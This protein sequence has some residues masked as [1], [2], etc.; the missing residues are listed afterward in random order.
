MSMS[1][2]DEIERADEAAKGQDPDNNSLQPKGDAVPQ[3]D[4][5]DR[6]VWG[7]HCEFFL[8][9]LG[10]AVGLGNIWR[11]P[12]VCYQNGGGTF[13]IPYIIMLLLVGLPL[14]FMEMS[15]GQYAGLSATKIYARLAPGLRGMGYGMITIPTIINFYYT[16]IMAYAF[17]FLFMGFTADKKLPW[18]LCDDLSFNTENC[19]SLVQADNCANTTV[20]WN[21]TCTEVNVF[22]NNFGLTS[23]P[24]NNTHCFTEVTLFPRKVE[25][26]TFRVSS[27]EEFW[28][29]KVL[30]LG[31]YFDRDGTHINQTE[32]S[33]TVWGECN[34]KIAGCLLLSWT[35]ICLSLIKGIQ[36]Y[37]KVVYFTTLFPYIVLTILLGYVSTLPGFSDGIE[38]YLVPKWDKLSDMNVWNAAAG[39]IFYSLG[40]AVGSQL[41]LSSYNGFRTNA[42]RDALL[43]GLCN[44]LTSMYAGLVVFGVVG[45]IAFKKQ[46]LVENVIDAGPGLAFIVYPEAVTAM[47][48][49][50]LFSF[51]FFFMLIL[52]AISSVCGSW[53]ALIAS[54]M[55]EFPQLRKRRVLVMVISCLLAFLA[56][57]PICFKSGFFLFQLMD[58]RSSNAILLMAFM[59]LIIISWFYG[60]DRFME[61]VEEMGMK[62]FPFMKIYWKACWIV[63]TPILIATVTVMSWG[64]KQK[65]H[66]L[67]Y[68]YPD[69]VQFLGWIIELLAISI[70]VIVGIYTTIKKW[71][72]GNE[73]TFLKPGIMM[74]PKKSWGKRGDADVGLTP[75]MGVTEDAVA[76]SKEDGLE[77]PAFVA[78]T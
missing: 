60:I 3:G 27:S 75:S 28:Y 44:S 77:N 57:F 29:K 11:F 22:C 18:G 25:N 31:V 74:T 37:G 76:P 56:G 41:L 8:S 13:L 46:M 36:S 23:V 51:L 66:Y 12:Y 70:V 17:Y 42:H 26:V 39:Q 4:E 19:Y 69:G 48:I 34:W 50:P 73:V 53:E 68:V 20:F 1:K 59:E 64:D 65:D 30:E 62:L 67:D 52:L 63:I 10:L 9:S 33:W 35:L 21:H 47:D 45:F 49:S 32:S 5:G 7:N 24:S 14:F 61:H 15:L 40:V 55:D 58:D 72:N 38:F 78:S 43:I 71:R 54:V 6:A 16:V 2:T